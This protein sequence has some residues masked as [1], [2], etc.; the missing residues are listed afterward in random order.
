MKLPSITNWTSI[1]TA[2]QLRRALSE[3]AATLRQRGHGALADYWERR[4]VGMPSRMGKEAIN[5]VLLA[6][7]LEAEPLE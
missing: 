4:L 3:A 7:C 1:R 6:A 5:A 2:P